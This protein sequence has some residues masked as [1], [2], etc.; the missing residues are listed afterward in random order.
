MNQSQPRRTQSSRVRTGLIAVATAGSLVVGGAAVSAALSQ[1]GAKERL[2]AIGTVEPGR[3]INQDHLLE[4]VL[5]TLGRKAPKPKPTPSP[6]PTPTPTPSP[7]PTATPTSLPGWT[8]SWNDSFD[9]INTSNWNVIDNTGVDYD[10][11]WLLA[12]NVTTSN[13]ILRVQAK[14]ESAG[15]RPYTSGYLRGK[16]GFPNYF[17]AEIRA[18]V[19]WEQGLWAAPL[20]FRPSDSSAGEID[21]VE[22]YGKERFNPLVHQTVHTEYGATHKQQVAT[23]KY[24]DLPGQADGWHTYTIEKTPGKTRM[25]VDG[26]LTAT[27]TSTSPSWYN[28]Y[29]EVGKSWTMRINMQVGGTWGG[30]PDS[31]T[32]WSP[33]KTAMLIDDIKVWVPS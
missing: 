29:Y 22:T 31:T 3:T 30:L 20:W 28:A 27:F 11:A 4:A 7:T 9:T 21:L 1:A 32:D 15:G 6:T 23:Y 8:L 16:V 24:A 10:S 5:G 12:R 13:G 18:K 25:W 19:P 17:R 26:V 2:A 14:K 33:D